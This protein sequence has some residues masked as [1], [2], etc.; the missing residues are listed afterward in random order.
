MIP[1]GLT[2]KVRLNAF[3]EVIMREFEMNPYT[4]QREEDYD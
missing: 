1:F 2:V 4:R 3:A